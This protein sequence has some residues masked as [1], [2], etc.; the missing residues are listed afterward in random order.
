MNPDNSMFMMTAREP[1]RRLLNFMGC[2]F[3]I[4]TDSLRRKH[5]M[6]EIGIMRYE[7]PE[8]EWR[9]MKNLVSMPE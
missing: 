9:Y 5:H 6:V 4:Q 3:V 8:C 1:L 7:F 2:K